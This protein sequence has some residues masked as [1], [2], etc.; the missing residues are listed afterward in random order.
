MQDVNVTQLPESDEQVFTW[1]V[2][3]NGEAETTRLA[4]HLA[5]FVGAGDLITLSGGL[6][7]GKTSFARGLIRAVLRDPATEVPSPTFT[8]LQAYEG[9]R[10][11]L[12]HADLFRLQSRA[13]LEALGWEEMS[14]DA[15]V[16]VEWPE[17]AGVDR[18]QDRLDVTLALSPSVVVK[19]S[20]ERIVTFTG[21][22]GWCSRL[23]LVKAAFDLIAARGWKDAEREFIQ[24]DASTRAYERLRRAGET[25]ILMISPPR[26]DGPPLREGRPY[27]AIAKLAER[28]DAFVAMAQ[29][30]AQIGYSS[31]K[32]LGRDLDQGVLLIED[33]GQEGVL[34]ADGPIAER[35]ALAAD[36]LADL[37]RRDLA[38]SLPIEDGREHSIPRY[39]L[40]ALLVEVDLLNDW[41]A[42]HV[43]GSALPASARAEFA[44]HWRAALVPIVTGPRSWTLRDFHSPNL[45]WLAHRAGLARL[46][47]LDFQD[48]VIGHPAYDLASLL[49]DARVD[50][51]AELELKLLAAYTLARK[52]ADP[53]FDLGSFAAAYATLGAQRATKILGIFARLDRR[54]RKPQYLAHLPRLKKYLV[55][56]LAHPAL[57]DLKLWYETNLPSLFGAAR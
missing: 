6:G 4:R 34:D 30:L 15:L 3:A 5:S 27:S 20:D 24:G 1:T 21:F 40:E 17:R 2:V 18:A 50:V 51:P 28:A 53:K 41:Y 11:P 55:R 16:L 47:L 48:A 23:R 32:I 33:L 38:E 43:L 9:E 19:A 26:P 54:D 46:G 44:R 49:Q 25:A 36:L 45:L 31:P 37:H 42:P 22:G 52:L 57:R 12:I 10:F 8:L 29:G 39:D 14:E 13:D 7:V 35:Y 56:N